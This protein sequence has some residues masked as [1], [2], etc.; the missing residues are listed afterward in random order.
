M[1]LRTKMVR[2]TKG[3]IMFRKTILGIVAVMGLMAVSTGTASANYRHGYYGGY[4]YGYRGPIGPAY[5]RGY[6]A[7]PVYVAPPVAYGYPGV[8]GY[9]YGYGGYAAPGYGYGY[10]G[11]GLGVSTPGFGFY[12]R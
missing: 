10:G 4:R 6:I 5:R 9:G 12:V 11:P 1:W 3:T 8:G 7:P 2:E